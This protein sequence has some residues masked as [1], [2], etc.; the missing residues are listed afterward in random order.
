MTL[1]EATMLPYPYPHWR[2]KI[3]ILS[4]HETYTMIGCVYCEGSG[5]MPRL[6]TGDGQGGTPENP[7]EQSVL[8]SYPFPCPVCSGKKE[9]AI[10]PERDGMVWE[11]C[12]ICMTYGRVLGGR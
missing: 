3:E 8:S 9:I 2:D 11:P 10:I 5:F 4:E 7:P 1:W 12:S 6:V